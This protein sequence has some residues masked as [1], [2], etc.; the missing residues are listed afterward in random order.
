MSLSNKK[1]YKIKPWTKSKTFSMLENFKENVGTWDKVAAALGVNRRSLFR[2]KETKNINP[3]YLK[4]LYQK[5]SSDP[6]SNKKPR[7][8]LRGDSTPYNTE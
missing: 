2:W 5:L 6:R 4:Y 7:V 8:P 1:N 3:F